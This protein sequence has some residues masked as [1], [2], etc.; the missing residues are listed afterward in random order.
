MNRLLVNVYVPSINKT[1][2]IYITTESSIKDLKNILG[3]AIEK[4][5]NE[6]FIAIN[7]ILVDRITGLEY[8]D[9]LFVS[10]TNIENGTKIVLI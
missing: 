1:F 9:N 10:D 3:L 4:I 7:N 2:D 6:R 5:S 8:N